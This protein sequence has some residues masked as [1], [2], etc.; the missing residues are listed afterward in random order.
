MTLSIKIAWR[1]LFA[2]KRVG[3]INIVSAVAAA[4]VG[5]VT[6]AMI[7]VLSVMNGFGSLVEQMFSTFDPQLKIVS[8]RDKSF[9]VD[10][11]FISI[12]E[13]P[14][15]EVFS[16]SIEEMA[17][18]VYDERQ[19][20]VLV[21][22]VS[23]SF[24]QVSDI[25]SIIV[26][27]SFWDET[28]IVDEAGIPHERYEHCLMGMGVA[29]QLGIS[30][31]YPCG[32]QLYAPKRYGSISLVRPDKNF[33]QTN[34]L[35]SGIF[36]VNQQEYDD[37]YL[38]VSLQHARDLFE[39]A[40]NEVTYIELKLKSDTKERQFEKSLEKLLG[41]DYKVLNRYEQ[42]ENF[43]RILQIEKLL[44]ALLLVFIMLI[45]SFN[46]IGSLSMLMIDKRQDIRILQQLGATLSQTRRIFLYEGWLISTLGAL[47]GLAVGIILCLLQQHFGF[48][49]LGNGENY[50]IDAYPVQLM[51]TDV[52][53][54][55][56][57][58]LVLGFIAAAIP[59]LRLKNED[60]EN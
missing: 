59:T 17:L 34:A 47:I 27:G 18:A 51:L 55:L 31:I 46:I 38:L 43:F 8:A 25:D 6:A 15:V 56:V 48:I 33:I 32:I 5:V 24:R 1:Y 7:C 21:K 60:Y 26:Y 19:I 4:G 44:T 40:E 2:K 53:A 37:Q 30:R 28:P 58:V 29:E 10:S 3:A 50:I 57:V 12:I 16:T 23:Q 41:N 13:S 14:Q 49:S 11:T 36:A 22:G 45:A 42:Q 54:V 9:I 35:L 39:Y 52:F 20:P